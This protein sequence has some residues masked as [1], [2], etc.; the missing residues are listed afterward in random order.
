MCVRFCHSFMMCKC[1]TK[2]KN[3]TIQQLFPKQQ[4][5]EVPIIFFFPSGVPPENVPRKSQALSFRMPCDHVPITIYTPH[6]SVIFCNETALDVGYALS[7]APSPVCAAGFH[8]FPFRW[9]RWAFRV[10]LGEL[11]VPLFIS[12]TLKAHNDLHEWG[13][14]LPLK[15]GGARWFCNKQKKRMANGPT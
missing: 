12:W 3:S 2:D 7:F 1:K 8:A 13:F 5:H 6:C 9:N 10:S 4:L 15:K 11:A 14:M